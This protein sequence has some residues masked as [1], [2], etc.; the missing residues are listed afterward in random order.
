MKYKVTPA[1][2]A[3]HA[4]KTIEDYIPYIGNQCRKKNRRC[5]KF[6]SNLKVNTIKGVIN[7][8]IL[9]IPAYTFLEDESFVEC[10][11]IHVIGFSDKSPIKRAGIINLDILPELKNKERKNVYVDMF[12]VKVK[13]TSQRYAVFQKSITCCDCGLTGQYFAVENTEKSS[14]NYHLNLYTVNEAGEEVLMTKDHILAI[15]NGGKDIMSNY[16][17]MCQPCNHTKGKKFI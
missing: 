12:G 17:T 5:K 13:I 16:R 15:A 1:I 9:N 4:N 14:P 8:P 10:R 6:K 7:H 2:H 11:A 3:V